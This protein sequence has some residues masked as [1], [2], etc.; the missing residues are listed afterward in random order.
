MSVAKTVSALAALV[1]VGGCSGRDLALPEPTSDRAQYV[2]QLWLGAWIAAGVVGVFVFG[3]M[4]WAMVR[5]RRRSDDEI[6]AQVRYNLPIEVLYTVA[7][8]IIV[9]VFFFHTIQ[10]GE[11][12]LED[13]PDPDHNVQV[14]GQKWSWSFSY[15]EEEATGGE[16]VYTAGT[17]ADR[18]TLVLPVGECVQF[19]QTSQDVVHAFW[20]PAFYFKEDVI[21]GRENTFSLTPTREGTYEGRCS[22]LCGLYHSR[23]LFNVEV[24]SPAEFDAHLQDLQAA[25]NVGVLEPGSDVTEIDGETSSEEA[26]TP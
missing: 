15:L 3:L 21:P 16:S 13:C 14:L 7:P 11:D 2:D 26:E 5:Y 20:V 19:T 8:I 1:L 25:G 18:P 22:E 23:M 4:V 12:L 17:P 10:T 9:L 24:V 6:P